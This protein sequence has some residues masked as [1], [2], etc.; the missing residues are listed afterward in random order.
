MANSDQ[1][2][3]ADQA[4]ATETREERGLRLVALLFDKI[5][6]LDDRVRELERHVGRRGRRAA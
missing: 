1:E 4:D 2:H 6:E 5:D 3:Y